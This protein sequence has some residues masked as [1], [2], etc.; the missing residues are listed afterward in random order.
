MLQSLSESLF[1]ASSPQKTRD[2]VIN[3]NVNMAP[4]SGKKTSSKRIAEAP[5]NSAVE[6]LKNE[7]KIKDAAIAALS[8]KVDRLEDEKRLQ[9]LEGMVQRRHRPIATVSHLIDDNGRQRVKMGTRGSLLTQNILEAITEEKRNP[10]AAVAEKFISMFQDPVK[11]LPYLQSEAFA[12]ELIQMSKAVSDV[13]EEQPRC[14]F[15]QSPVYV[16]G[17]IHG[18]LEDLHFFADNLWKLGMDLAAGHFLFLGDYVDRGMSCLEV[19]AYLFALKVL[20]P[21]KI[22]MLRGNHETRDVN[23][24]E[25]HYLE[26]SFLFQCKERFGVSLGETVWEE[27]N[28]AFDRLP[29]A[30]VIDH[31]IFCIHGG[32]PRPVKDLHTNE[33]QAILAM[34]N[35]VSIMPPYDHEYDWMRQVGTDCIWSDP[36][37][38]DME[39]ILDESGFGDSPRGGGAVC[40]GNTAIENFLAANNLSYIIRAHEA[41]AYGVAL[42]KGARVFTVFSTSKDHRQGEKAMAGCILVDNEKI[43]VINRSPKYKNRYVHRRTSMS[44]ANLSAEEVSIIYVSIP[45]VWSVSHIFC[46]LM[47]I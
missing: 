32:I 16:F 11:F 22:T 23:G 39:T 44:V 28:Q 2:G 7:L 17:D 31:E 21:Y 12:Q 43:Q 40:F 24:W 14:I 9:D 19:V 27:I 10:H 33:I 38:E 1:G 47:F 45:L 25:A 46:L 6:A 42:S 4:R 35:I 3:S 37:S 36:A 8:A 20:Y 34:P 13:F 29:L 26:K 5:E 18:N 15:L 41:H 30:A